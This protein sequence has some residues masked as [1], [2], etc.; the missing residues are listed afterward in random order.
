MGKNKKKKLK[1][2]VVEGKQH[3][4]KVWTSFLYSTFILLT[5]Q[6]ER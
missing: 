2:A 1:D 3:L 6:S 5:H 4:E